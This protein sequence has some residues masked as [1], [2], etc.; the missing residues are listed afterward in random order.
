MV[1]SGPNRSGF[2]FD[3]SC[4]GCGGELSLQEDFA[5]IRCKHCSSALR[6]TMPALPPAFT[7]KPKLNAMQ[8]RF[9]L[10][11]FLKENGRPLS[12]PDISIDAVYQ[13]YWKI[14]SLILRLRNRI[15]VRQESSEYGNAQEHEQIEELKQ[16]ISLTPHPV[17]I[18]ASPG[19]QLYP[20]SLG[21]RTE[22]IKMRPY[23]GP[24]HDGE[25][26]VNRA[27]TTVTQAYAQAEKGARRLSESTNATNNRNVARLFGIRAALVYFPYFKVTF[28]ENGKAICALVDAVAA[29]VVGESESES[30]DAPPTAACDQ[31]YGN[32]TIDFHR[33]T[34]CGEDLPTQNSILYSC[35]NCGSATILET[36]P[37][38]DRHVAIANCESGARSQLLPFWQ[39]KYRQGSDEA[40][41]ELVVP[42]FRIKNFEAMCRL[43]VRLSTSLS[44]IECERDGTIE[45]ELAAA[46]VSLCEAVVLA[47]AI[48]ARNELKR[49][50]ASV[51]EVDLRIA[52]AS[53]LL[54]PFHAESYF[55]VDS[56][57][58]V[59]TIERQAL[60]AVT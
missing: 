10:D 57:L 49:N 40:I 13:P 2:G 52:S 58:S 21:L 5:T 31:K 38:F 51:R 56:V 19:S 43:A 9:H 48:L 7:I 26:A 25:F 28:I 34:N 50:P 23:E 37:T 46:N 60:A 27:E 3:V 17:T 39:M 36:N 22:Y 44:R 33:C 59:I 8:V 20:Y 30:S 15:D 29:R 41:G 16:E 35:K 4:P 11:R 24:A 42:A 6:I 12:P 45:R 18:S 14:D 53:L 55:L 1:N 47:H 54:I 32:L